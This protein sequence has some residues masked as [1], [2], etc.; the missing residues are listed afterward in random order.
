[1]VEDDLM[2]LPK[3]AVIV[4]VKAK[5]KKIKVKK[6]KCSDLHKMQEF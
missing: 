3:A 6:L 2:Q 1:M 4:K 5:A